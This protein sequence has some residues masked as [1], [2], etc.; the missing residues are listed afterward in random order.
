MLLLLLMLLGLESSGLGSASS[1]LWALLP[2][3][4]EWPPGHI[5]VCSLALS[6]ELSLRNCLLPLWSGYAVFEGL[7]LKASL[8]ELLGVQPP[9]LWVTTRNFWNTVSGS[10]VP[11]G[12][13]ASHA[14]RTETNRALISI[15]AEIWK[16]HLWDQER[17]LKL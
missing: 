7:L 13:S 10:S 15:L 12:S 11:Y 5:S 2:G 3:F 4:I 17:P 9:R 6:S 14:V 16:E 1:R 8:S